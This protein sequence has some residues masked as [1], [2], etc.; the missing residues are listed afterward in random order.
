MKIFPYLNFDGQAEQAILFYQSILGGELEGG[1]QYFS[2]IPGMDIAEVD[3]QRV[4]HVSLRI[5]DQVK[6]MASD[7]LTDMGKPL[8]IGNQ[9]YLS[10]D[11]DSKQS[12]EEIF[13]KLSAG[14]T[15]EMEFQKTFWGAYFGS[16]Q[17]KFGVSWMINY[18]LKPGEA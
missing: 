1:I 9:N 7:T 5:N 16:F 15:V 18:D 6:I 2:E 14:G 13:K 11:A 4:M 3:Q 17:D 12:G 10:I 8:T